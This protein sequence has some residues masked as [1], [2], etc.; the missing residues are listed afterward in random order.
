MRRRS[1]MLAA[2]VL[3]V[4][5][6]LLCACGGSGAGAASD[7]LDAAPPDHPVKLILIHHATGQSWLS[8]ASG[9]LGIALRDNRYF[10]SD[11]DYGW[12]PSCIE[13]GSQIGDHTDIPD[14]YLWFSG[15]NRATYLG[16]LYAESGQQSSYSRLPTDPGGENAIILFKSAY[17]N[18][19]L[20]G[21]PGDA[22]SP[23]ADN[24][25]LWD[26]AHAK[27]IYLDLL[28]YFASRTDKLF[29]VITAPPQITSQ[30]PANARAF[31]N[32]LVHDWLTGY[33]HTNVAVFDCFT[34]LTSNGGDA[35]TSDLGWAGGNHHRYRNGAIEHVTTQGSDDAAYP[36]DPGDS[37]PNQVGQLKATG[38]LVPLL[39]IAY[40]RWQGN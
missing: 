18:S 19:N 8:D 20:A 21:T 39:N 9:G 12:G 24:T 32:W 1:M 40:H 30:Y 13:S 14:W 10:V 23:T 25:S 22:P 38:E 4:G 37:H 31:N 16:S 26:V 6:G 15:V 2:F 27:R 36:T 34:V 35:S 7:G 17:M 29:V 5:L 3:S 11:T 28:T 33:G